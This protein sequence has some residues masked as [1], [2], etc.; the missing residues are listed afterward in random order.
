MLKILQL[1][2]HVS[3]MT[4]TKLPLVG[5]LIIIFLIELNELNLKLNWI[6]LNWIME[7]LKRPSTH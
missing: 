7:T 6:K 5:L 4:K 1:M 2:F 3:A